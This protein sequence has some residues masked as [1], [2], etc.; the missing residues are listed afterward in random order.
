M[1]RKGRVQHLTQV[2]LRSGAYGEGG[3]LQNEFPIMTST[4]AYL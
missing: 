3:E 2:L 4:L 1:Q